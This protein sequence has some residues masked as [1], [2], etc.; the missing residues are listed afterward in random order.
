MTH[1]AKIRWAR[2]APVF[3]QRPLWCWGKLEAWGQC[4]PSS[5]SCICG[6]N[7]CWRPPCM[8]VS[9]SIS[10]P[11]HLCQGYHCN[12]SLACDSL[13]LPSALILLKAVAFKAVYFIEWGFWLQPRITFI[14]CMLFPLCDSKA[15]RQHPLTWLLWGCRFWHW[16][17]AFLNTWNEEVHQGE[18]TY[19]CLM[20]S[21]PIVFLLGKLW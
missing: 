14:R 4:I 7:S 15:R 5:V 11:S 2:S 18:C 21:S 17:A 1:L 20:F 13:R 10:L 12:L 16:F 3:Q 6:P 8:H 9:I 19:C